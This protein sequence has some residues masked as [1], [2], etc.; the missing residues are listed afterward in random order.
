MAFSPDGTFLASASLKG[1]ELSDAAT[2]ERIAYR[3]GL[4]TNTVAISPN[5]QIIGYSA[6]GNSDAKK[7][8]GFLKVSDL[9]DSPLDFYIQWST[10]NIVRT[11]A[12][13]PDDKVLA[14]GWEKG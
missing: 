11:M 2:G 12:F 14:V 1:I 6:G 9:Y 8:A 4:V 10:T 3:G 7:K 13:K 5:G